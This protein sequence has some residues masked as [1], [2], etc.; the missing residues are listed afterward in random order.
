MYARER[1]CPDVKRSRE[2][3][4]TLNIEW[5]EHDIESDDDAAR[6][7]EQLTGR[8]SVPTIVVGDAVVVEPSNEELDEVLRLAGYDLAT[9]RA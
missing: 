7:V 1:F 6:T 2:H 3:L 9:A 5:V 4:R 8:R